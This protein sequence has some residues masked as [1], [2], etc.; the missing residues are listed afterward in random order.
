MKVKVNDQVIVITGKDSGKKGKIVRISKKNNKVVV[1]KLNLRIKHIKKTAQKAGEKIQYEAAMDASNVMIVCPSCSKAS[2]IGYKKLTN[3][4]KE[5]I[6]KKCKE[7]V[8]KE[9]P[10][11][12]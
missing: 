8:D 1:E 11:K 2:R 4:K 3:G 6:C 5:R 10:K 9:T 7:S 12:K